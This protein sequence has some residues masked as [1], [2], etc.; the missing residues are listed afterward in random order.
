[1]ASVE[2]EGDE[3]NKFRFSEHFLESRGLR[4]SQMWFITRGVDDS[5]QI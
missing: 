5:I 1:M 4:Y 2:P 3:R